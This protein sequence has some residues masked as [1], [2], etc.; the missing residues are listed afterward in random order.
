VLVKNVTFQVKEASADY[1]FYQTD[2]KSC[3]Y[4]ADLSHL[5]LKTSGYIYEAHSD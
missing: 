4:L 3:S 1:F 5:A 2:R